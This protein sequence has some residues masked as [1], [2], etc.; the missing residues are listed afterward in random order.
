MTPLRERLIDE[1]VLRGLSPRTQEAYV[2][3][4]YGLAK[5]YHRSPD[6][7][8]EEEIRDYLLHLHAE[9]KAAST[10]NQVT[11]G[12]KFF[13]R[14]VLNHPIQEID[15]R[16][17]RP[18]K[19]VRRPQVFSVQEIERLLSVEGFNPKHRIFLM[20]V[21]GAG[22]RVGEACRLK[23]EHILGERLQIRVVEGKGNRD[24]YVN[25]SPKLLSELRSYWKMFRPQEWLFPSSRNPRRPIEVLTGQRIYHRAIHAAKLPRRGGIHALRHSFATHLMEAGVELPAVQRLMGHKHLST[26]AIYL[27]VR[28]ERLAQIKSPLDLLD[29]PGLRP[30]K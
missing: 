9:Q 6:Q 11:S 10:I 19:P 28:Q 2:A 25:L 4:V 29:L 26:T 8:K 27:H 22:L 15:R 1:I 5:H 12:L 23:V 14:Y 21:Y 24:R 13:Y 20:T 7:I 18:K 16:M 30:M 3:A 17:P